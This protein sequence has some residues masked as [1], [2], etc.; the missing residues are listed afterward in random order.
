MLA[1]TSR[2]ALIEAVTRAGYGVAQEAV[3]ALH[4]ATKPRVDK[5]QRA[6]VLAIV[7]TLPLLIPMVLAL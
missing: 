5:H 2:Q 6:C 1:G 3:P 4:P 7:L